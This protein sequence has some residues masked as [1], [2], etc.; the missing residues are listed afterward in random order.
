LLR[1]NVLE[2]NQCAY[3]GIDSKFGLWANSMSCV[4][5][6]RLNEKKIGKEIAKLRD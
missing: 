4:T 2:E 1:F 3:H 5:T 6:K